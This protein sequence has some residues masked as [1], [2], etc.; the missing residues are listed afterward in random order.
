MLV[1]ILVAALVLAVVKILLDQKN[2]VDE[3]QERAARAGGVA[4]Q[5]GFK[6]LDDLLFAVGAGNI[7][8]VKQIVEQW[9]KEYCQSEEG[10]QKLARDVI[11]ATYDKI[12]DVAKYGDE[13]RHKVVYSAL[14]W[15]SNDA[16]DISISK[17]AA[18][19]V[20]LGWTKVADIIDSLAKRDFRGMGN[21]IRALANELSEDNGAVNIAQRVAPQTINFLL[22]NPSSKKFATD[23][24]KEMYAKLPA[25][26]KV[27]SAKS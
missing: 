12:R 4:A 27:L 10:P 16:R 6:L 3:A 1:T 21:S 11:L 23:L 19:C 7:A 24:I 2:R 17:V 18:A 22:S 5:L 9:F 8:R 20:N 15:E 14:G 26:D 13:V 25:E